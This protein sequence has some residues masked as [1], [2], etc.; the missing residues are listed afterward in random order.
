METSDAAKTGE[1]KIGNGVAKASKYKT[2]EWLFV[3]CIGAKY[4]ALGIMWFERKREHI[5]YTV[6]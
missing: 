6:L 2:S 4:A 5:R 1:M 3:L